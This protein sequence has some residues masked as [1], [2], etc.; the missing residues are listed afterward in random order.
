MDA[1]DELVVLR[2]E[3]NR[4][5]SARHHSWSAG[6]PTDG[7]VIAAAVE[8]ATQTRQLDDLFTKIRATELE[9][10]GRDPQRALLAMLGAAERDGLIVASKSFAGALACHPFFRD[11]AVTARRY[12]VLSDEP[13][14]HTERKRIANAFRK[15]GFTAED[16]WIAAVRFR[17]GDFGELAV[18][19]V[20]NLRPDVEAARARAADLASAFQRIPPDQEPWELILSD[21]QGT[22]RSQLLRDH[23]AKHGVSTAVANKDWRAAKAWL[24]ASGR[25]RHLTPLA[26]AITAGD[27]VAAARERKRLEAFEAKLAARAAA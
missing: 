21:G 18:L 15:F 20:E 8:R 3:M 25:G 9:V 5:A 16:V 12:F 27:R 22:S 11:R 10:S 19:P 23:E 14:D 4:I 7:Q 17:L 2:A 24:V 1:Y 26:L 6:A 13:D